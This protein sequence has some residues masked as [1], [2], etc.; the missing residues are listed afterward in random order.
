VIVVAGGSGLLG[1]RVAALLSRTGE[2][3]RVIVRDAARARAVLGPGIEACAADVRRPDEVR[4][5]VADASV[6][7]SAVH[8]FLGGRGAGP[9]EVDRD[10]NRH[11][12][13]AAYASGADVVLVSVLP[14]SVDSPVELFRAKAQAEQH[15]RASGADWTIVRSAPFLETWL[16]VLTQTAGRSGRPSIFGTG[17]QPISFVAVD[18]VAALVALAVTDRTLRGRTLEISGVPMTMNELAA[19]LQ[20][21]RGWTGPPRHVPR[22]VLRLLG[23]VTRP[24]SPAFARK[25]RTAYYLDTRSDQPANDSNTPQLPRHTLAEVLNAPVQ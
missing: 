16:D 25:S 8:G 4:L 5:A 13:E 14:A 10:G 18:D 11:L 6:V 21:V 3:V 22:A 19:A 15:L 12:V 9:A 2:P 7:V 17:E 20:E 24:V 1:R 23:S